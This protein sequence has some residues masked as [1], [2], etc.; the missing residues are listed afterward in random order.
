MS[1]RTKAFVRLGLALLWLA[2]VF[3][4]AFDVIDAD[5]LTTAVAAGLAIGTELIAWWKNNNVT[6]NAQLAQGY[7]R[8]LNEYGAP[9]SDES[10]FENEGL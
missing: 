8:E 2:V 7:L 5:K 10:Y 6:K 4:I 9:E 3:L 1:E